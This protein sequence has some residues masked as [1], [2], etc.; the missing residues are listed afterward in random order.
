MRDAK[1]HSLV[2]QTEVKSRPNFQKFQVV[3]VVRMLEVPL[4]G[5]KNSAVKEGALQLSNAIVT[6][7]RPAWTLGR[8]LPPQKLPF[9]ES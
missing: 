9:D 5:F 4:T 6:S 7:K 2:D 1:W 8:N 3:A